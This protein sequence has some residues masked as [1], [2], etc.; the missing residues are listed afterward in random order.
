MIAPRRFSLRVTLGGLLI[1]VVLLTSLGLGGGT[2]VMWRRSMRAN[3]ATRLHDVVVA[4]ALLVDPAVHATLREPE[5][6]AGP[7]YR[8]LRDK[9]V[10][11]RGLVPEI[12]FLYTYRWASG[13]ATPRFVLDTGVGAQFS[14][15]G[16]SY[17]GATATLK[18]T[19]AAPYEVHV[20]P[21]FYTDEYGTFLSAYAP[22]LAPDGKLEAVL[23]ADIDASAVLAL[24]RRLLALV[25]L[26]TLAIAGVMAAGAWWLSRVF[27]DSLRGL[28]HD[29]QRIQALEIDGNVPITS[30]INEVV[31]MMEAFD[32]MKR[33]LRSFRKYV[34]REIVAELILQKRE[35]VLGTQRVDATVFF[36]DLGGFT[37]ASERLTP[38]D[39]TFL[40]GSYFALV[41]RCLQEHGATIDKFVG[42]GVMAFWNAP[43]PQADHALL[44]ARAALAIIHGMDELAQRWR[45]RGLPGLAIR[46]GL[47][48]GAVLVGNVGNEDRLSYTV[49]GD[50]VNLA[51]RLESLNKHYGTTILAAGSTLAA[52]GDR[53]PWRPVDIV[54][55]RGKTQAI[56]VGELADVAPVWWDAYRA[57]FAL[58]RARAWSEAALAFDAIRT[59]DGQHDGVSAVLAERCHRAAK[60]E[61]PPDFD[62]TWIMHEK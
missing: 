7:T 1:G 6:M 53:L 60:G 58:Y 54:A 49:L 33:G 38:D 5:D 17:A 46:V 20:E 41:T 37:N 9:L 55:V 22:V 39:L 35:A 26:L 30:R 4:A 42:D 51:S 13:E 12:H 29:M 11:L 36:C 10:A 50:P 2:F 14:P 19:F 32:N 40:L 56:E 15:L 31:A 24:E 8:T 34:P 59:E 18:T 57:A 43:A 48:T 3:L 44:A 23:G 28:S 16:R 62:G 27:S 25:S 45:E 21:G 52:I 47:N 61:V